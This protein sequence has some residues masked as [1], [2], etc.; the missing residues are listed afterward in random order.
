MNSTSHLAGEATNAGRCSRLLPTPTSRR[1]GRSWPRV[2]RAW[3]DEHR[4]L[5]EYLPPEHR[6]ASRQASRSRAPPPI[7]PSPGRTTS[8][9]HYPRGGP[10]FA[11]AGVAQC[12]RRR[13]RGAGEATPPF[14]ASTASKMAAPGRTQSCPWGRQRRTP[15]AR[16]SGRGRRRPPTRRP[17]GGAAVANL[18]TAAQPATSR[19]EGWSRR[20]SHRTARRAVLRH[21]VTTLEHDH[22]LHPEPRVE[23]KT[24]ACSHP[25]LVPEKVL[26]LSGRVS[27]ERPTRGGCSPSGRRRGPGGPQG[28]PPLA[29]R[30][31]SHQGRRGTTFVP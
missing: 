22:D 19:P 16:P 4:V 3:A 15:G 25:A 18:G 29:G 14:S 9:E 10:L 17:W 6:R 11:S 27:L 13:A 30:L 21:G 1:R 23:L 20:G 8:R 24:P 31:V 2:R 12:G 26:P 7:A 28:H 5:R